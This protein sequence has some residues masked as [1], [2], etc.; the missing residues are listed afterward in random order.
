MNIT[1][2]QEEYVKGIFG[3]LIDEGIRAELD[4]RNEKLGMKI[5]EASVRK[6][7]YMIVV[8][9][10]EKEADVITVR[11]R[12]GGELKNITLKEF[13]DRIKEENISRR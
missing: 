5:R 6:I 7:P 1:D 3:R 8:G 10:K 9:N 12:D 4:T 11:V 13:V 2:E